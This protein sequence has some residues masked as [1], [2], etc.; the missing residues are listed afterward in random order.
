[1]PA[2]EINDF[3]ASIDRL[4]SNLPAE[5]AKA[6][7][8]IGLNAI[9]QITARLTDRGLTAE[10]KSLGTYSTN[11]MNPLFFLGHGLKSADAKIK[12]LIKKQKKAG[13]PT[14][15]SYEQWREFNNRPTEHVT[16]SFSGETLGDIAVLS[17]DITQGAI[18]TVVGSKNSKSKDIFNKFGKKTGT[19]STGHVL[20][21][22]N[23][24]YGSALDTELLSMS[25]EEEKEAIEIL[26]Q[27]VQNFVDKYF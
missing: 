1:M 20:D 10:G 14:G 19:V 15:V 25:P 24:K 8:K 27:Q 2:L 16:L 9:S 11:P 18:V 26:D 4:L 5:M 17:D 12:S 22:L 7:Q 13:Q 23:N 3:S 21:D 6:N